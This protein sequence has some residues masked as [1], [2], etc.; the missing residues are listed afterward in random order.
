MVEREAFCTKRLDNAAGTSGDNLW[1]Q[2]VCGLGDVDQDGHPDYLVAA[3]GN[4]L[5]DG[6]GYVRCISG[7]SGSILYI[8]YGHHA[9]AFLGVSGRFWR[10]MNGDGS[11][12]L[13]VGVP[14]EEVGGV[15]SVGAVRMYSGW[16]DLPVLTVYNHIAGETAL[17]ELRNSIP[18]STV[19]VGYSLT[20]PGPQQSPL[21]E[22]HLSNP[23]QTLPVMFTRP[24]GI[25]RQQVS[26]P[27]ASAGLSVFLHAVEDGLS[28]RRLS[29]P[30]LIIIQ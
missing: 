6:E 28:G 2:Q 18:S 12:E 22:I 24:H 5:P 16:D 21:G 7:A 10:D 27:L 30:R 8:L 26:L 25:A 15:Q 29:N 23:I 9:A 1:G 20:G 19:W 4:L 13:L 14:G 11:P 17:V 3:I